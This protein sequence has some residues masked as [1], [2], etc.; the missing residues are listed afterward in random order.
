MNLYLKTENFP[1]TDRAAEAFV[2]K[3]D[4]PDRPDRISTYRKE[5]PA[6]AG[7]LPAEHFGPDGCKLPLSLVTRGK[8]IFPP[9]QFPAGNPAQAPG[10]SNPNENGGP[11]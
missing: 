1:N 6:D 11:K 2:H 8:D 3:A 7:L 9:G 4:E 10:N 5:I